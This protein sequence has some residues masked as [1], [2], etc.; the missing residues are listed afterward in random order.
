MPQAPTPQTSAPA[1][2]VFGHRGA[3]GYRPEHTLESYALA[4]R[5]GADYIEPD[6]VPTR[7]GVLVCRHENEISTTTDV[8]A[9]PEFADRR[10]AKVVDGVPATGWFTEDF[11][12]AELRR[13]RATERIPQL[14]P[15]NT[16]HDG[17]YQVPTFQ[18]VLDLAEVLTAELGRPIGVAPETK[19]P[20]HFAR[21]GLALEPA[22]VAALDRNGLNR[23]GAKLVVQSFEVGN[24]RALDEVAA[25]PLL[26]LLADGGAPQDLLEFGDPRTYAD[27]SAPEGLRGVA[28]YADYIGPDVGL[29]LPTDEHGFLTAPTRLVDD[30]QNEGL[31]VLPYTVRAENAFLPAD[32]RSGGAPAEH[33]DVRGYHGAL[34]EQR[35]DAVFTDHPDTA[36][37]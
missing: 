14:R 32:F 8:S 36:R 12:L 24:L 4:A 7:D 2:A 30:A 29:V 5:L 22:L 34:R 16:A 25:V 35:I 6:L 26:Q 10:T 13:L 15:A 21:L 31:R 3:S 9:R 11:E 23:A 18:E 19:H 33:G 28:A 37:G 17:C 27:L 1:I 20:S